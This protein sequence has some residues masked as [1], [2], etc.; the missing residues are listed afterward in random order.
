MVEISMTKKEI[1][2]VI[3]E[4]KKNKLQQS[5][6]DFLDSLQD[7]ITNEF[8][9][10]ERQIALLYKIA[11]EW[12]DWNRMQKITFRKDIINNINKKEGI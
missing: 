11:N 10:S 6:I 3:E 4:L 5:T 1:E 9:P 12:K 8:K 7:A 2:D